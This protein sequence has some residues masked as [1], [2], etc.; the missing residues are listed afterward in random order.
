VGVREVNDAGGGGGGG[1]RATSVSGD[2]R[3]RGSAVAGDWWESRGRRVAIRVVLAD[4]LAAG[5]AAKE[6]GKD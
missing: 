1:C 2:T 5:T 4:A 6:T 3:G